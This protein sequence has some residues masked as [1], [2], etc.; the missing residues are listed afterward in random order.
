MYEILADIESGLKEAGGKGIETLQKTGQDLNVTAIL[1]FV[2]SV[3]AVVA[4][5]FIV[6]GGIQ[7]TMTQGDPG[8]VRK[9]GQTLAFAVIGLVIVILA[10][11]FTNFVFTSV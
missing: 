4:V 10:T 5:G 3:A 11:V 6:F 8:K 7:Y 9:A 1:N 2:Y